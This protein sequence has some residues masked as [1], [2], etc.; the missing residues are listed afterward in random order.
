MVYFV[1]NNTE[2]F[3]S[4]HYT[5]I[6]VEQS[7][8]MISK[9]E[10]V[11]YDSETSGRDAHICNILCIQFGNR[12]A[13]AQIVVDISTVDIL[14]Y[15]EI[16]ESKP[17]IGQNLKFDLQFLYKYN[18]IPLK[19]YDTMI[20]EQLLYLGYP[21][22]GKFG[23]ISY[24]L[25]E[26]SYRYLGIYLDKS[27]RGEIIWRGL[28]TSVIMYAAGDVEYLEDIMDAQIEECKKKGCFVGAR[29]ECAFVPVIA[30]L[31]W[32]GIRLSE[33][34]WKNKM[35]KDYDNMMSNKKKLDDFI[36]RREMSKYFIYNTQG[37]L[38]S[39]FNTDPICTVNW[40]SPTQVIEIANFLGFNTSIVDKKTGEDK[41]SVLEKYLKGQKGIDDEFLT[42]YFD[43]KEAE[44]VVSTYGQK[45]LNAINP[46]TG[47]IHTQFRQIGASSGRMAC[48]SKQINTDLAKLKGL[49]INPKNKEKN[50]T[51]SYPQLQNLPSDEETRSSFVPN[52]GNE[53]CSC[54]YSALESRLGA[55][56]YNDQAMI[57]EYLYGSGDIHS[58]VAKA[59]FPE[60]LEGVDVK[61]IKKLF[62]KL[63]SKAKA[64]EFAKQFG[65]GAKSI[66]ESLNCSIIEAQKIADS[67]DEYF[68]GISEFAKTALKNVKELGY[69]LINEFTGHKVYWHDWDEW[70]GRSFKFDSTYWETYR[71]MK[72]SL[73]TEEFNLTPI[74]MEVSKHFKALSKWGRM[75]LNSPTQGG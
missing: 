16:L 51:C 37:D 70:Q 15:K 66:S 68:K 18:I 56:I 38:F 72:D 6:T 50:K 24:A 30:Y 12:A 35:I 10:V 8:A 4:E 32:S 9:W 74:K 49:P 22:V 43:Y 29:L 11:Q 7:V 36:I 19:I 75:G 52:P 59:C 33:E 67:Y 17:L 46:I 42:I 14:L 73:S 41:E 21:P 40:A 62:P 61:D 58:L 57:D 20:V 1:S 3:T 34:K 45:Y 44:K 25:N 23:G 27:V 64:P 26:I 63:R 31:E 13:G 5:C 2:L 54:D 55:D 60:E 71:A 28:D 48:G 65:G 47:R 69:V 39:G 53:M